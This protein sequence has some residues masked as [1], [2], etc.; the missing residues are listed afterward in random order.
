MGGVWCVASSLAMESI[1][2][3]ARGVISGLFQAGDPCGYFLG[4]LVYGLLFH[5]IGWR[6]LFIVGSIPPV[7]VIY[8]LKNIPE[9]PIWT[10]G[11]KKKDRERQ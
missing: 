7:I 6:R 10:E 9:S 8:M 2:V 5:L 1:P 3:K 11:R 4:A